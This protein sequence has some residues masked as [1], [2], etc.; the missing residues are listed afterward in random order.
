MNPWLIAILAFLVLGFALDLAADLLN[1]K[2]LS[3]DLPGEFRDA[4]DPERYRKSQ[5]YLRE[6]T[7]F[8][9]TRESVMFLLTLAFLLMGG[10][11]AADI[12]ARSFGLGPVWTGLVFCLTLFVLVFFLGI[13]WSVWHTFRIEEKYGFNRTTGR[14][15]VLDKV[16]SFLL[17]VVLGGL[18]LSVVLWFFESAGK[19]AWLWAWLAFM[20]FQLIAVFLA[21]VLI[22]PLFNKFTP[23]PEGELRT[24][25]AAYAAGQNFR[26]K[27]VYTMDASKRSA[28]TN[29]FFTG[30]GRSRRIVLFDTLVKK[31]TAPEIVAVLAHETGHFKKGH[32]LRM[33]LF[34]AAESFLMFLLLSLLLDNKAIAAAFRME[35]T[36]VYAGLVFFGF[37]YTPVS[38]V[39]KIAGNALSRSH[40]RE[41]DAFAARTTGRPG[42]LVSGLKKLS[43]DNLSNLTPHPFKV[44]L[45]YGH[46]PVLERIRALRKA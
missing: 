5:L 12:F 38:L 39:L 30:L 45:E 8:G 41:A 44:A 33:L 37:L 40:E 10:F 17:T 29:A 15:F 22:M 3:P 28:K 42:D 25:I 14:T 7:F 36:S 11:N 24:A 26:M 32:I 2:S 46:P 19:L 43:V 20:G 16:K 1:L 31:L 27:G 13:P 18:L 21:P 34:S 4:Y 35:Q 9:L 6:N 23:L